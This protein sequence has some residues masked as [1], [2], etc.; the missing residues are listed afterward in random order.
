V[1]LLHFNLNNFLGFQKCFDVC[2]LGL[3]IEFRWR[4]FGL[5][6][7]LFEKLGKYFFKS[8]GHPGPFKPDMGPDKE[9]E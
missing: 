4:Y 8:S 5:F 3:Q 2:V 9:V 7:L 6:G 1:T